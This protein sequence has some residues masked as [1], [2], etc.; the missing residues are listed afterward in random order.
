MQPSIII[1]ATKGGLA[2]HEFEFNGKA[3]CVV[4]RADDCE[5]HV[6]DEDLTA[7]RHHCVL[8]IDPPEVTVYDLASRNGTYVNGDR[9]PSAP[10]SQT[11]E[12]L[13]EDV[14]G[15]PLKVGDEICVGE[16]TL[17]V[18]LVEPANTSMVG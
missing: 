17:R 1:L 10:P 14:P 11:V 5:L 16:T 7:S 9:V 15:R 12:P 2:G 4:G 13:P 3:R 18:W 8:D 6:P